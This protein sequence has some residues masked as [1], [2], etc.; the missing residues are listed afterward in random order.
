[1]QQVMLGADRDL[2]RL[3]R[4]DSRGCQLKR[5]AAHR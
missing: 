5:D 2:V 3:D 1:M 4:G